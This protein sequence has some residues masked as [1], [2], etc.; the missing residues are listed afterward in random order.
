ML[1]WLRCWN[2]KSK[3]VLLRAP[4]PGLY[5]VSR[6]VSRETAQCLQRSRMLSFRTDKKD[7]RFYLGIRVKQGGFLFVKTT[8][9]AQA[10]IYNEFPQDRSLL[11][12]TS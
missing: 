11:E 9:C 10:Q 3:L 2:G 4:A 5:L 8:L 12:Q 1:Q 6:C 7:A